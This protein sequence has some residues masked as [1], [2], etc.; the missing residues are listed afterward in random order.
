MAADANRDNL[1]RILVAAAPFLTQPPPL[2]PILQPLTMA[3]LMAHISLTTGED[4][5]RTILLMQPSDSGPPRPEQGWQRITEEWLRSLKTRD[6]QWR[7]RMTADELLDLVK[8]LEIPDAFLSPVTDTR[9]PLLR[10][11]VYSAP[12]FAP[13]ERFEWL[14]NRWEHL[15][16]CDAKHL[17]HPDNL[18]V[19]AEAVQARGAPIGSIFAFL[20]CTIRRICRPT[21]FQRQA[22][23]GHKKFHSL[24]YQALMLPN[25]IIGHL[26]DFLLTESGLLDRLA[27]FAHQEDVDANTPIERLGGIHNMASFDVR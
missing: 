21:W 1:R 15:L 8:A 2:P 23:N 19:Y 4:I 26:A 7:F 27:E 5:N 16:A 17:L 6:C 12:D 22:Y 20:D 9:S 18:A 11:C 3:E 14:D 25:G 10:L 24:K 13:L